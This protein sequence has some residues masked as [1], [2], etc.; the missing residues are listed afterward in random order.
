MAY[1]LPIK[2]PAPYAFRQQNVA[3]F[4]TLFNGYGLKI[5]S[6]IICA[7]KSIMAI[8]VKFSKK[9]NH[10]S[11]FSIQFSYAELKEFAVLEERVFG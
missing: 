10:F 8:K 6:N 11:H 5:V 3:G 2:S 4:A 1:N 9:K 7:C